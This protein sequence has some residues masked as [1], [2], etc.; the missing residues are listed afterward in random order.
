MSVTA[1]QAIANYQSNPNIGPQTLIDSAENVAAN[2]DGLEALAAANDIV[3]ISL[4]DSGTPTLTI[5]ATQ[6]A[7]DA[8]ALEEI[9]TPFK[10]TATGTIGAAAAA[11]IPSTLA[12]DLTNGA[13]IA[14]TAANGTANIQALNQLA[15]SNE[16]AAVVVIDGG[17]TAIANS[18]PEIITTTLFDAF[19]PGGN[20]VS[21]GNG[22]PARAV[23]FRRP[24]TN[25]EGNYLKSPDP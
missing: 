25:N 18:L 23:R 4:T 3:S 9:V 22:E 15:I 17:F 13:V 24:A 14:D 12:A 7:N 21:L 16:L 10:I 19:L 8:L 11:G 2:L 20:I 6:L 1:A 5:A